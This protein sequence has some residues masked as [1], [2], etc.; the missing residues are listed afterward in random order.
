MGWWFRERASR[1]SSL[2]FHSIEMDTQA[3][4]V[5]ISCPS[6]HSPLHPPH[7]R[8]HIWES[9][10]FVLAVLWLVP[11]ASGMPAWAHR[12]VQEPCLCLTPRTWGCVRLLGVSTCAADWL[13]FG[14]G[15]WSLNPV[16]QCWVWLAGAARL[17][18]T[19]SS[20]DLGRSNP[21]TCASLPVFP[22][23]LVTLPEVIRK[24]FPIEESW[25]FLFPLYFLPFSLTPNIHSW[26]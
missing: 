18:S 8:I 12:W 22:L 20:C 16:P 1:P 26:H 19:L 7:G 23:Q 25:R 11:Q 13:T 24:A 2:N 15:K 10:G 6:S 5:S 3:Q 14:V 17:P 21:L 9:H 4:R